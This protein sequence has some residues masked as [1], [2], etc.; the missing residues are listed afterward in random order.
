MNMTGRERIRAILAR[1]EVDRSAYWIG[2]P[3]ADAARMY[4]THFGCKSVQ[5]LGR[6]LGDDMVWIQPDMYCHPDGKPMWDVL[7]GADRHTLGQAGVFADTQ[8]VDEVE[9]FP[10]WPD[11]QYVQFAPFEL[12]Y[13]GVKDWDMAMFSGTWTHIWHILLDFF[14]M[15]NCFVKMYTDPEVVTAVMRKMTDFYLEVNRRFFDEHGDK[16]DVFFFGNDMGSQLDCMISP[17][18]FR[19][20]IFPFYRQ[21][22]DLAKSYG[23]KVALHSC[24]SIDR[25][26]PDLI[27]MGV[28]ILHPIQAKAA[29]MDAEHLQEAYGGKIVFLGG[30]DTQELLPFGS[31]EEV[32]NEVL[33]LRGIFGKHFICSPSHEALLANVSPQK[34]QA[35]S[36]AA[37]RIL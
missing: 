1:Q 37:T 29:N 12:F 5:E 2:N 17:E 33:R 10:N 9:R 31:E 36:E 6:M 4:R 16:V 25:I 23:K 7:G 20:F 3:H 19:Q 28:D 22:I 8:S 15:E 21:L 35:M 18:M 11:P 34:L 27:D 24:G 13:E 30:V 26:I 14:G 32:T